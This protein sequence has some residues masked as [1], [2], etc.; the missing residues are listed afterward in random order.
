MTFLD[1]LK[2]LSR[3]LL[4]AGAAWLVTVPVLAAGLTPNDI[5]ELQ[6][7]GSAAISPDG[8]TIAYTLRVPRTL[9]EDEEDGTSWAE[10]HVLDA[11]G[12][13][14]PF[15][16]GQVNVGSVGWTPDGK[17]ISFVAKRL[18]DDE[19]SLYVIPVDGGEARRVVEHVT[20]VGGYS[21]NGDGS[22]VAFLAVEEVD[23]D[24]ESL[25]EKGFKQEIYEE[26]GLFTRV[27]VKSVDGDDEARMLDLEGSASELHWS[28]VDARLVVGLQP[29]PEVDKEY[30]SRKINVVDSEG[31]GK[32]LAT[33]DNPG[34]LGHVEWSPD[35]RRI[36]MATALDAHDPS[37]GRLAVVNASGGALD[38][39]LGGDFEGD[40]S[41]FTWASNDKILGVVSQFSQRGL[42]EIGLDGKVTW[43]VEPGQACWGGIDLASDGKTLALTGNTDRHLSEVF[44]GSLSGGFSKLTDSN[45]GLSDFEMGKQEVFSYEARDGRRVEGILIRP[46]GAKA[47]SRYPLIVSVHGGPESY[48]CNGW[49]TGYSTAGQMAAAEGYAVFS[50]NYRGSTGR[51]VAFAKEHQGDP[52]GKEF[53][54]IVDGV[55]ALIASGLVD[56]KK[57]GITGGSYGGFATAWG[58][59]YFSERYAAAVMF[60]GISDH[61]SKSG[62]TDIPDEI[63]LVHQQKRIWEDWQLFLERS[64]IYHVEKARTPIL[65]LHGQKDTRVNPGQSMEL[66]RA[67][68]TLGKT[69]VRY[70]RYPG[71]GHGN[72]KAAA[73]YDYSLRMMRWFDHYLKGE[74]GKP[75]AYALDYKAELGIEDDEEGDDSDGDS[76][77]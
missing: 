3:C 37:P 2:R 65:I 23:E 29:S 51:G 19:R 41:D 73:R 59:T 21:F 77:D 54:D 76:D 60:V 10:L 6:Q 70:V 55:D 63:T 12:N 66:Y 72:R 17:G 22:Q 48:V 71:E 28:P 1:P 16:T 38:Y 32:V 39:L 67:L 30:T 58:A 61:I 45:P 20:G 7:A 13:S 8:S 40:I 53:N 18:G 11:E 33:F 43:K 31:S 62:T 26:D 68:K 57:V 69:P 27:W 49:G 52:A 64:P 15:I 56:G 35:G 34:K 75:P 46:V 47:G 5:A 74:G 50:P 25:R 9:L 24:V 4:M 42:A 44:R 14:R 36:A